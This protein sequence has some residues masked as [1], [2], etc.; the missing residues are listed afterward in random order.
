MKNSND[1][2]NSNTNNIREQVETCLLNSLDNN[3]GYFKS[4]EIANEINAKTKQ[5]AAVITDMN[6]HSQQLR[7]EKWSYTK[8]TTWL[9]EKTN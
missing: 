6:S 1:T 8:S 3:K 7:V 2:N 5:V 9:V 4:K